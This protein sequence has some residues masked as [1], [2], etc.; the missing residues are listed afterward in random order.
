M[1]AL[2]DTKDEPLS[3]SE[4][5]ITPSQA[6]QLF[7]PMSEMLGRTNWRELPRIWAIGIAA[8]RM[9]EKKAP[10]IAEAAQAALNEVYRI[11]G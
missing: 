3:E 11:I 7:Q 6:L 5:R 9:L 2:K 8:H 4:Q 1:A 10:E